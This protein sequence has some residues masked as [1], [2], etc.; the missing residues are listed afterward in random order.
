MGTV[1][2]RSASAN[3]T[4]T[5]SPVRSS[6]Q[7][8][9][10]IAAFGTA[11]VV[12]AQDEAQV[13]EWPR[14]HI[15][16]AGGPT[17]LGRSLSEIG[18]S[19]EQFWGDLPVES[20]TG[21]KLVVGFRPVRVVG[22]EIQYVDLGEGVASDSRRWPLFSPTVPTTVQS[23]HL[24]SSANARVLTA[25]LFIPERATWFDVYGKVGI[26]ELRESL[27]VHT[28][29]QEPPECRYPVAYG[30]TFDS[31]EEH[32]DTRPYVGF[33]ARFKVARRWAVRV[34]YEAIDRD[35]G[36][37]ATVFSLGIAWEH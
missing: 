14:L 7:L 21:R 26:A 10:V 17:E 5:L 12:R 13:R 20:G 4:D 18:G 23:I 30:C 19:L 22:A 9:I 24:E 8:L 32:T 15:G 36:D 28:W 16:I 27:E 35:V 2:T 29:D 1:G 3:G 11:G 34:E 6:N 33:G 37:N 25:L 31:E